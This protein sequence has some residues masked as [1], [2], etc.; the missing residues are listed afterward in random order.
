MRHLRIVLPTLLLLT[1]PHPLL[2]S[3]HADPMG[4]QNMEANITGLFAFPRNDQLIVVLNVFRGLTDSPP[5]KMEPFDYTIYMDLDSKVTYDNMAD[6]VRYGGTVVNPQNIGAEVTI[7]FKLNDDT[8]L[9]EKSIDGLKNPDRIQVWTGVRDDPFIFPPFFEKNVISMVLSIPMSSFPDGQQD[10]LLWA[11]TEGPRWWFWRKQIDHVGRSNR[12]Q[13]ARFN[14]LNTLPPSEQAAAIQ[15]RRDNPSWFLRLL[16]N[17]MPVESLF[18]YLFRIRPY[19]LHPD[20]MIYTTRYPAG[21]PNGRQLEDDVANL[22]C[23]WGDCILM[24][25]SY[26]QDNKTPRVTTNDKPFLDT[27]PYLAEPWPAR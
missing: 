2:G 10:W 23:E 17:F 20:V 7:K 1:L 15:K 22:T 4:L 14:F 8:S 6:R 12:T 24:E 9:K 11:T 3:D 5:Y 21:F 27:F 18:N 13:L 26:V 16:L 25:L 19:D